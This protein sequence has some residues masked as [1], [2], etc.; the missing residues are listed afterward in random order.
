M[1]VIEAIGFGGVNQ[2]ATRKFNMK[3]IKEA[4]KGTKYLNTTSVSFGA[5]YCN[6]LETGQNQRVLRIYSPEDGYI[7]RQIAE[8]LK[9][10]G[11]NCRIEILTV[12][13]FESR[14]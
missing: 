6:D 9:K 8:L 11:F 14:I 10:G 7:G 1:L 12:E 5:K 13:L 4:L 3:K 2:K